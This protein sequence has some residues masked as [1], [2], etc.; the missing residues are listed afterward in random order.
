VRGLI[1]A[2]LLAGC[3]E[4]PAASTGVAECDAFLKRLDACI[5]QLGPSTTPGQA[6]V[7]QRAVWRKNWGHADPASLPT[8]CARAREETQRGYGAC[9]W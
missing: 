2:L 6:L 8:Q 7:S 3:D 5:A 1:F 9:S 4:P